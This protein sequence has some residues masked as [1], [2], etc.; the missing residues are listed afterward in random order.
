MSPDEKYERFD[1]VLRG[2]LGRALARIERERL[3]KENK[4]ERSLALAIAAG[5]GIVAFCAW[6]GAVIAGVILAIVPGIAV[7]CSRRGDTRAVEARF[8]RDI[9]PAV[10]A[11][12]VDRPWYDPGAVLPEAEFRA[13]GLFL[14]PD[15]YFGCDGIQGFVGQVD[16]RMSCVHAI[17]EREELVAEEVSDTVWETD[18]DGNSTSH[19][20]WR[21]E[22]RWETREYDIFHG[23]IL[24]AAMNKLFCGT[25]VVNGGSGSGAEA[26][27]L[28]DSE[29]E[30]MFSVCSSDQV[31][32]RYLLTP[33]MMERIKALRGRIGRFALSFGNGRVYVALDGWESPCSA[34][35]GRIDADAALSVYRHLKRILDI[36]DDLDLHT[37]VWTVGLNGHG[38]KIEP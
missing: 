29:W 23:I 8:K 30:A 34:P 4:F 31:E 19:T 1:S 35:A 6:A 32:A 16:F 26:V 22:W 21:T 13:T 15:R 14:T 7:A 5:L 36:I 25:T 24:S 20:E 12:L 33:K 9:V 17:E 18:S 11:A 28:E 37:R 38:E 2:S 10:L 3:E 27:H